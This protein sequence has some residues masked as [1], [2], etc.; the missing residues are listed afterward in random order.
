M[1]RALIIE[2]QLKLRRNL[3]Q[4]LQKEGYKIAAD[5]TGEEGYDLATSQSFDVLILDL[6]LPG[7]DGLEVLRDLRTSPAERPASMHDV[8]ER[9]TAIHQQLADAAAL[10]VFRIRTEPDDHATSG[11]RPPTAAARRSSS[12]GMRWAAMWLLGGVA[13]LGALGVIVHLEGEEGSIVIEADREIEDDVSVTVLREGSPSVEGWEISPGTRNTRV[14]RTGRVEVILPQS[15]RDEL[16]IE[17]LSDEATLRRGGKVVFRIARI[18]P[19]PDEPP[20]DDSLSQISDRVA[21]EAHRKLAEWVIR[22]GG[23]MWLVGLA[24]EQSGG[25]TDVKKLPLAPFRIADLRFFWQDITPAELGQLRP[26]RGIQSLRIVQTDLSPAHIQRIAELEGLERIWFN[27]ARLSPRSTMTT[28]PAFCWQ[29]RTW[30]SCPWG[31]SRW[32]EVF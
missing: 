1:C 23:Q 20:E 24:G 10:G 5:D 2:N 31:T 13:T 11:R 19:P 30:S 8:A 7:R 18:P 15:D 14:I 29:N 3:Q 22:R 17:R 12:A 6:T 16:K 26:A 21:P 32:M 9:L 25:I 28:S 4:L 27:L